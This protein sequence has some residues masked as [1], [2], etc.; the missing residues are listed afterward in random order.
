MLCKFKLIINETTYQLSSSDIKNWK[1][2]SYSIKRVDYGGTKRTF[3]SKFEFV[4]NAHELLFAEYSK[5]YL[6]ASAVIEVYTITNNHTYIKQFSCPLDFSSL[7]LENQALSMN[8][9]DDSIAALIKSKKSTLYEIPVDEIKEVGTLY[10]DRLKMKSM[11]SFVPNQY[12]IEKDR[13]NE[14]DF[15]ETKEFPAQMR[16]SLTF[17][18]LQTT[19][20]ITSDAASITE[21]KDAYNLFPDKDNVYSHDYIF[22][23]TSNDSNIE[24]T[25]SYEFSFNSLNG[26]QVGINLIV[27]RPGQDG[28]NETVGYFSLFPPLT[29]TYLN[30]TRKMSVPVGCYFTCCFQ[31][32]SAWDELKV[33]ISNF[34]KFSISLYTTGKPVSVDVISPVSLLNGIIKNINENNK[35]ISCGIATNVDERLDKSLIV[36]AES[37]RGL[38]EAKIYVSYNKF[39]DW[40]EAVFGFVPVIDEEQKSII[41]THRNDLFRNTVSKE[42]ANIDKNTS[43]SLD[44]SLIYSRVKVGYDK[45]EYN[46]ING[47]DEFHFTNEYTS[48]ITLSDKSYDLISPFRADPYGIEFLVHERGKDTTDNDSDNDVFFVCAE[49]KGDK[50]QLVRT[51]YSLEGVMDPT[52]M[53]NAM[54]SPRFMIAANSAFIGIFTKKLTFASSDGNSD[55]IINGVKENGDIDIEDGLFTVGVLSVTTDDDALPAEIKGLIKTEHGGN[56]YWGY[57]NDA[58]CKYGQYDGVKYKLLVKSIE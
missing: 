11:Y 38:S 18:L 54:F 8:A 4:N 17:P 13:Q 51:G 31:K 5:N 24:I 20:E 2:I 35:T 55:V 50:Y 57:M 36:A 33:R 26:K 14:Y 48:G 40:M 27:W 12:D 28:K 1:E 7:K 21:I 30:G 42:I 44:S 47:R 25:I 53:F 46:S 52:S 16:Q 32:N 3:T 29:S 19:N 49:L 10:Y 43:F 56:V 22:K 37:L 9:I 41:F 15:D 23:N 39:V 45:Q 34:K 6:K 58:S